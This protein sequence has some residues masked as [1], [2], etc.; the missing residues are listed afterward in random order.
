[1]TQPSTRE[2]PLGITILAILAAVGGILGLLGSVALLGLFSAAGGLFMIVG[3]LTLVLSVLYLVFAYGA[4]TL[5][6]WGWTLGVGLAAASV[7]LTLVGL[8]Q[9]NQELIGTLINLAISGVILYYLF[10]PDVKAAF[11]RT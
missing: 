9:G 7:V 10:Q 11:G 3:L 2:R 8:T 4:W 6:P 1:M 5:Q